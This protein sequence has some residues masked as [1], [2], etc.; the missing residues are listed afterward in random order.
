MY[1]SQI[2]GTVVLG[3]VRN[4]ETAVVSRTAVVSSVRIE[5]QSGHAS[6][7]ARLLE[8][9]VSCDARTVSKNE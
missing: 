4:V 9:H 6:S 3:A 2:R 1:H 5:I 8:P 7:A